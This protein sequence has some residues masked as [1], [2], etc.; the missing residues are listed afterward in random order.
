VNPVAA[1]WF[2]GTIDGAV[3]DS[4]LGVRTITIRV[5]ITRGALAGRRLVAHCCVPGTRGKSTE[6]VY[7]SLWSAVG[8]FEPDPA[9][10][11]EPMSTIWRSRGHIAWVRTELL[12]DKYPVVVEF[13]PARPR[14]ASGIV[15]RAHAGGQP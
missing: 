10:K 15:Q 4:D 14:A 11:Y 3:E 12:F 6:L 8:Q 1:G 13:A 9:V 2:V 5:A 7:T